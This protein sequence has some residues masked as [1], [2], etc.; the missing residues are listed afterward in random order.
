ML[1]TL[2]K[3]LR[4]ALAVTVTNKMGSSDVSEAVYPLLLKRG[5]PEY[6]HSDNGPEFTSEPFK[7]WL[8]QVG[9]ESIIIYTGSPWGVA[10]KKSLQLSDFRSSGYNER[11]NGTL[12]RDALN[13]EW[14]ATTRN[15]PKSKCAL[16][17]IS[18][19]D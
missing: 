3:H 15:L 8:T 10:V 12:R 4:Q 9:I 18:V 11:F 14:F 2:D 16:T 19:C 1:R 6:L 7:D 13:A 5:K 17:V